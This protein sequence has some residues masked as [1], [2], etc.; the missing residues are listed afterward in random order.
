MNSRAEGYILL[1]IL[2]VGVVLL[3]M[4]AS[5]RLYRQAMLTEEI[6]AVRTTGVYL[7]REELSRLQWQAAKRGLQAGQVGWLGAKEQLQMNNGRFA[8]QADVQPVAENAWQ[9]V[10]TVDWQRLH[11]QGKLQFS[12][13]I[14]RQDGAK[15]LK[16]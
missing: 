5:L 7:A 2:V 12:R 11:R 13:V 6:D 3:A 15:G 9:V 14:C 16:S 10:V 4:T 8:V 1:E